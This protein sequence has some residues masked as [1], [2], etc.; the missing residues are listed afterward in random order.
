MLKTR[1]T[2]IILSLAGLLITQACQEIY[3]NDDLD[4]SERIPCIDARLTNT[5]DHQYVK[6]YYARPYNVDGYEDV[7]GAIVKIVDNSGNEYIFNELYKG[8][9][10]TDRGYL[11]GE[12]GKIY[13]LEIELPDGKI[14]KSQPQ[15]MPDSIGM[16]KVSYNLTTEKHVY[17][18]NNG[19]FQTGY[20]EGYAYYITPRQPLSQKTYYRLKSDFYVYSTY[21]DAFDFLIQYPDESGDSTI[22]ARI[23][24][25][26]YHD[27]YEFFT[28]NDLPLV[29]ELSQQLNLS[30][31]ERT[32]KTQF[33]IKDYSQYTS[34][35]FV[36]W[37]I[38]ADIYSISAEAYNYYNSLNEQ[39]TAPNRIYDPIPNQLNGNMFCSSDTTQKV[40]GFFDVTSKNRKYNSLYKYVSHGAESI[41][42]RFY[43]DTSIF[44]NDCIVTNISQDTV[45]LGITNN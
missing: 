20:T 42:S 21:V 29:G 28:N 3:Y 36:E 4:A 40:L 37:I 14:I 5:I 18:D 9:Y 35:T 43:P 27:C 25:N 39:L 23:F 45:V 22:E 24:K 41:Q 12:I 38:L 16:D 1:Y 32:K 7:S 10:Q 11:V 8:Y 34:N 33:L 31:S 2:L 44:F 30:E 15:Q 19:E 26:T 17:T 6:L 13:T